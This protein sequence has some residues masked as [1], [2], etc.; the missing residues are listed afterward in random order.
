MRVRNHGKYTHMRKNNPR[1]IGTCDYSGFMVLHRSMK[2]QLQ[3]RGQG[4][5]KT[6]Y[7]VDPRFYDDPNPQDLTPLI[8]PDPVPLRNARPDSVVEVIIPQVLELDVSGGTD[9]LLTA[10][11]AANIN[12]IFKGVLTGNIIIFV[13]GSFNT[14]FATDITTGLFNISMQIANNSASQVNLIRN[15]TIFI[16]N[17]GYTLSINHPN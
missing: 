9:V 17:D 10:T 4:L 3:Y 14:F 16:T 5:V 15:Q 1:G 2:D 11:Q 6:G 12:F 13:P 8:K 7:R